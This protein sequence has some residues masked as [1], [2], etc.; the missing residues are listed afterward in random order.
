MRTGRPMEKSANSPR[1]SDRRK[2]NHNACMKPKYCVNGGTMSGKLRYKLTDYSCYLI[3]LAICIIFLNRADIC[4]EA[5]V[6][7]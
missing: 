1:G 7:T 4:P 6:T 5:V 2:R 3:S